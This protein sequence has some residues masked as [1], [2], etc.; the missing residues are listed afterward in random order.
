MIAPLKRPE[1][2]PSRL[3]KMAKLWNQARLSAKFDDS[4]FIWIPKNAGTSVYTIL[5]QYGLIK[6]NTTR[7]IRLCFRNSGRVTF[8]H[9]AVNSL[10]ELGLVSQEF[11]DGAFKFAVGRNPY[12][13]A[14]SLY[15]YLS[16]N[17]LL[18]W[19]RQPTFHQFIRLIADGHYD[20]VGAY[21]ARGISLCSPQVDWL[22]DNWPD[23]LY[24]IE[25]LDEFV[26]DICRRWC[27]DE[28][29]VPRLNVSGDNA[30]VQLSREEKVLIK[31]IYAEDFETFGYPT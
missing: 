6:L 9:M 14:I 2:Y 13:R 15:R 21:N 17:V 10:I 26:A 31:K 11:V 5:H 16:G 3:A 18:N 8:G 30:A 19:H 25:N 7:D 28:M 22:R 27:I 23:K 29:S 1:S 20:R 4:I 12:I 24:N